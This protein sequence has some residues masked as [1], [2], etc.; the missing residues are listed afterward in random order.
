M[1]SKVAGSIARHLRDA[2]VELEN[3]PEHHLEYFLHSLNL[4]ATDNQGD[5]SPQGDSGEPTAAL[6]EKRNERQLE[7][8]VSLAQLPAAITMVRIWYDTC[9]NLDLEMLIGRP[10]P[11]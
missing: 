11:I 4:Q 10:Q 5:D 2:S 6:I 1:K 9:P 8:P 7:N 3:G